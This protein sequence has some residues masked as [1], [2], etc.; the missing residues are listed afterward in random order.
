M[1]LP[2]VRYSDLVG[3][4]TNDVLVGRS[5]PVGMGAILSL[6]NP[7]GAWVAFIRSKIV[8]NRMIPI[9][10]VHGGSVQVLQVYAE[11]DP[12]N[13]FKVDDIGQMNGVDQV[14]TFRDSSYIQLT[15]GQSSLA[16][17]GTFAITI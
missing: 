16:N 5:L 2:D 14:T 17:P 13:C 15:I 1:A 7:G 12:L 6:F 4:S 11:T 8:V 3:M 9:T 10:T